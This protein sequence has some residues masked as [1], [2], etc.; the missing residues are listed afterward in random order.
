VPTGS[1]DVMVLCI[2]LAVF[3]GFAIEAVSKLQF[4]SSNLGFKLFS[5]FLYFF[6]DRLKEEGV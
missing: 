4:S 5:V 3:G 6:L 2:P 1:D